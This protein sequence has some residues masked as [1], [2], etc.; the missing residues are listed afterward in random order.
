MEVL[1][2]TQRISDERLAEIKATCQMA[3]ATQAPTGNMCAD[4]ILAIVH[5]LEQHRGIVEPLLNMASEYGSSV[6]VYGDDP[7]SRPRDRDVHPTNRICVQVENS[8]T[9]WSPIRFVGESIQEALSRAVERC[10]I[11]EPKHKRIDQGSRDVHEH[12]TINRMRG[13]KRGLR[14]QTL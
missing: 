8:R 7:N 4:S 10:R 3:I 13:A 5:E 14:S 6:S 11:Y 12:P 9:K 2:D 1:G